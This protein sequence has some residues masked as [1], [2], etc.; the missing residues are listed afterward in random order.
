MIYKASGAEGGTR[1]RTG[2]L[3]HAP[4]TCASTNS[5][6]SANLLLSHHDP[7][8]TVASP[9]N[10]IPWE[11]AGLRH[12]QARVF[13]I[14]WIASTVNVKDKDSWINSNDHRNKFMNII[15]PDGQKGT[16]SSAYT[17]DSTKYC[18]D[19]S[20]FQPFQPLFQNGMARS[21]LA[22]PSWMT[23]CVLAEIHKWQCWWILRK[24]FRPIKRYWS[25]FFRDPPSRSLKTVPKFDIGPYSAIHRL[26]SVC[27]CYSDSKWSYS[28]QNC[29]IRRSDCYPDSRHELCWSGCV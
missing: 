20:W 1:S 4:E 10:H 27:N 9:D 18:V 25:L 11:T 12:T 7:R 22:L 8:L 6:T 13:D 15:D 28:H 24:G 3:P 5:A 21:G 2:L 16:G 26:W 14:I 19:S 23:V 29:T 17:R